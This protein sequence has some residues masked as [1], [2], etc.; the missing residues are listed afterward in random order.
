MAL[1]S[2]I[3]YD[4]SRAP[5][6]DIPRS[7]FDRTHGHKTTFDAGF[8]I[9]IFVDEVLP[10]DTF[11]LDLA[12]F[13]RLATPIVPI[14]DNLKL[15]IHFFYVPLRLLWENFQRF[16]GEQVNPGDS[17]DYLVPQIEAPDGGW[18]SGSLSDYF[19]WPV[20]IPNYSAAAFWHRAYNSIWNEW[21]RDQNL[22]DSVLVE[23]GD[24]PDDP[25]IYQLLRRGK[26][27]DYFTSCLPWPQ[28]GDGVEISLGT[29]AP[30]TSDGT[31]PTF[32]N[33]SGTETG[34][35]RFSAAPSAP[36]NA[37]TLSSNLSASSNLLFNNSGLEADLSSATAITINSLRQAF[38]IQ[39]L[40]ERDAR[41]GT[42]YTEIVRSHFG[43]ISPDG[44]LQRPEFLGGGTVP[45]NINP[46]AQTSSTDATTP[47]GNLAGFGTA[48]SSGI[49][50]VKSFV[51]HGILMG[52][53]SVRAD[54]TYQQGLS[55]MFSRRTR[56]DFYFPAFSHLGEQAVLNK[57]IYLSGNSVDDEAVFGYQERWAEYRYKPSIITGKFRSQ[58]V[59]TLDVWH[60][61][62]YFETAPTLS[63]DFIVEDPPVDRVLALPSEPHFLFDSVFTMRCVRPMPKYSIPGLIDHF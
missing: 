21:F 43:V 62:Q 12:C 23:K 4:F 8:L 36:A 49:G 14:M 28:K 51:E 39:K 3:S 57:E 30:V 60:L 5:T 34:S 32:S 53:A 48:A 33:L 10:G 24:G 18:N 7:S 45:I 26:R 42:R 25:A 52:L 37:V 2:T 59:D 63:A 13:A 44:R 50:F 54:L 40:L 61:A 46:V 38:Q 19:G 1:K 35:L 11:A 6:A 17:I 27:H 56:Y 29:T 31:V 16:M 58:I 15:D 47:Q 55:R 22:Q 20:A 9:P 41:G